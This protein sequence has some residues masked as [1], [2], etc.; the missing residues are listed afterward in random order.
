MSA[1]KKATASAE[2]QVTIQLRKLDLQTIK[3][4]LEGT[5]ALIVHAWSSKAKKQMLDKQM[6]KASKN[7][8]AKDPVADFRESLYKLRDGTGYGFPAIG[9]KSA[10]VDAANA[11]EL[12]KTEMRGAFHIPGSEL[13]KIEGVPFSEPFTAEDAEYWDAIAPERAA[14]ISMRSDMVRI[15]MGTADIRFRGQFIAW[16]VDVPV[17]YNAGVVSAEQIVNLFN[18]AGF[19]VGV[20]EH[21]PQRD[22]SNGMFKVA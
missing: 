10:A 1:A 6:R 17:Q 11:M 20:G 8:D 7:K 18:L 15:A 22:G 16:S 13:L 12:K 21:R 19:A 9:F 2:P 4:R 14:G 5:S 3:L